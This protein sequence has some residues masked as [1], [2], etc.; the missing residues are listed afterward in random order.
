ME[1]FYDELCD[2]TFSDL[3]EKLGIIDR[4][5]KE[6]IFFNSN[7][8]IIRGLSV[9]FTDDC[10]GIHIRDENIVKYF[11]NANSNKRVK[12]I[13]DMLID[14]GI[15][16]SD[17][18]D[19]SVNSMPII[20][21]C[22]FALYHEEGHWI[23]S[24]AMSKKEI[25]IEVNKIIETNISI[26]KKQKQYYEQYI[27]NP[28]NKEQMYLNNIFGIK[29]DYLNDKTKEEINTQYRKSEWEKAADD[30]A[31]KSMKESMK[32]I[33]DIKSKYPLFL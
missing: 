6:N 7:F 9:S 26:Y 21:Y 12:H 18:L 27:N 17:E 3:A 31:I 5:G 1:N 11:L 22:S 15:E 10:K 33:S 24:L 8:S 28:S 30:Y 19:S 13:I 32:L 14:N 23:R 2:M 4:V 29:D 16:V 20:E 25:D